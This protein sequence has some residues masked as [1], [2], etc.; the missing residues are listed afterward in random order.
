[1]SSPG[2]PPPLLTGSERRALELSARGL[3]VAKVAEEMRTSP[4]AVRVWLASS[5]DK[6]GAHSKLE[7]VLS[8]YR[9][10]EIDLSP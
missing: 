7:A 8:A 5:T 9:R 4:S 1:M 2:A 10:G 3:S 6:L